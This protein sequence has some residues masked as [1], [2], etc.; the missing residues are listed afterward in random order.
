MS[1]AKT[2][3]S[4]WRLALVDC[5]TPYNLPLKGGEASRVSLKHFARIATYS[6]MYRSDRVSRPLIM[7]RM[8][9]IRFA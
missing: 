6:M 8:F 3:F 2:R 9:G 7:N 4:L 1:I 5:N